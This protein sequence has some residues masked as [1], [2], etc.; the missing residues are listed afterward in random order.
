LGPGRAQR[1]HK[2]GT[3]RPLMVH[4]SP[5]RLLELGAAVAIGLVLLAIV[6]FALYWV[7]R[8]GVSHALRDHERRMNPPAVAEPP[9]YPA[10]H[11][12]VARPAPATHPGGGPQPSPG[13]PHRPA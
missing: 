11:P 10:A 12:V 1:A 3:Y 5:L 13:E 4:R 7:I 8:L 9:A 2:S 6:V